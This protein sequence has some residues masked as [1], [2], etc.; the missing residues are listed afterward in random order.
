MPY[1]H[2][3]GKHNTHTRDTRPSIEVYVCRL[4]TSRTDDMIKGAGV[5]CTADKWDG[6]DGNNAVYNFIT[7]SSL[8]VRLLSGD[9]F[10]GVV[11]TVLTYQSYL[12]T[13]F[14]VAKVMFS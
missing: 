2:I 13:V 7:A 9:E 5:H 11:A 1:L 8:H 3:N 6:N 14:N 10:V 12:L 4:I